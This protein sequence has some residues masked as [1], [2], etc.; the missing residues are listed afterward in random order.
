MNA[1]IPTAETPNHA[2][3]PTATAV[4][5]CAADRRHLSTHRHRPR[6]PPP[7]LSLGSLGVATHTML[8]TLLFLFFSAA[9]LVAAADDTLIPPLKAIEQFGGI[10]ISDGSSYFRFSKD[11]SFESGPIGISGRTMK[12][13]WTKNSDGFFVATAR[14]GWVNGIS[15]GDQY[16]RI[17]F[18]ISHVTKRAVPLKPGFGTSAEIFDSYFLIDEM[19]SIPK[20]AEEIPK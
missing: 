15:S 10:A 11:G 2:L 19:V 7:W 6:Q 5:A 14:L 16:R 4:T 17:V 13:H 1:S 20:P 12:G 18:H 9:S 8:K 3:Q